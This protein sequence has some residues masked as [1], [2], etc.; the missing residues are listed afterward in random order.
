MKKNEQF[1]NEDTYQTL[2]ELKTD[3]NPH[4]KAIT[5]LWKKKKENKTK[6]PYSIYVAT[7]VHS[8]CSIH[9]TQAL[10]EFQK[11]ALDN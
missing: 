8:D 1:V 10:L 7:P 2:T 4:E 6:A 11:L 5:P 9:Y 3:P